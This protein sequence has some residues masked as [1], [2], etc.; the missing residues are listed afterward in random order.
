[1]ND[2]NIIM[3]LDMINEKIVELK[4]VAQFLDFQVHTFH[5]LER[6]ASAIKLVAVALQ[7]ELHP[8]HTHPILPTYL[9]VIH[10]YTK[11]LFA[12]GYLLFGQ[13]YYSIIE[14]LQNCSAFV[15]GKFEGVREYKKHIIRA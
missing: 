1:M 12:M 15:R 3:Y 11:I 6:E 2:N 4:G 14:I 5:L 7:E 10:S 13:F 9:P 8:A